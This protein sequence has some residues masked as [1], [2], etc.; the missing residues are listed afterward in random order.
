MCVTMGGNR[1]S[2]WCNMCKLSFS[3]LCYAKMLQ[4]STKVMFQQLQMLVVG[5]MYWVCVRLLTIKLYMHV[6][7]DDWWT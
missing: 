5:K 1:C 6:R 4:I 7:F 3:T 2:E